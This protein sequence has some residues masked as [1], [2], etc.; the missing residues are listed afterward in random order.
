VSSEWKPVSP[1]KRCKVC[2]S[3]KRCALSSDGAVAKCTYAFDGPNVFKNG[4]DEVGQWAMHRLDGSA[5]V[6]AHTHARRTRD[7]AP[8][9]VL[10]DV[11]TRH[12][13]YTAL[14]AACPL[15]AEHREG[16]LH[17][18]LSAEQI[19][20]RGY[21]TLP[22]GAGPVARV[23][24]QVRGIL[25]LGGDIPDG[26]PGLHRGQLPEGLSGT[27]IPV[28]DARGSVIAMKVRRDGARDPRYLWLSSSR[29]GGASS[30]A[31]AHVPAGVEQYIAAAR[32]A[33]ATGARPEVV[34]RV[35]EGELKADVAFVL[36]GVPTVSI[37]GAGAWR[38][39]IEPV[40]SLAPDVLRLAWDSDA[41]T[42]ENVAAAL[43]TAALR[44]AQE[45]PG[46]AL[47]LETWDAS[48]GKGIDDVLLGG[49]VTTLHR[50]VDMWR[51]IVATLNAAG[52][53]PRAETLARVGVVAVPSVAAQPVAQDSDTSDDTWTETLAR[54][55]RREVTNSYGN[56]AKIIRHAPP[57]A[58]RLRLN[59]MT[60]E[61]E[62]NGAALLESRIGEIREAIEDGPAQWGRF[63]PNKGDV[64]DAVRADAETRSYHPVQEF[65]AKLPPW[66]RTPRI[67]AVAVET[68]GAPNAPLIL[69]M[70]RR[71]FV[72]AVARAMEPGCKVD[73]A[74]VLLG[75]QGHRKSSFFA[76][77]APKWFGDTEIKLGDKDGLQQI[78]HNWIT[79]WAEID[80]ITSVR[81][82][83]EVKTFIARRRDCFR[84]PYGMNTRNYDRS[85]V[86]VGSTNNDG[87]L[88]DPTGGRRFW[89]IPVTRKIDM[90]YVE[91]VRDQLWAE[92]LHVYRAG[93]Q[94]W[95]TDEE[96]GLHATDV[97]QYRVRDPWEEV[98]SRWIDESWPARSRETGRAHFTTWDVMSLALKLDPKDA[99]KETEGRVGSV[100][101]ALGYDRTRPSR[102]E[103]AYL[104]RD[105]NPVQRPRVWVRREGAE[106][107]DGAAAA[108]VDG[109]GDGAEAGDVVEGSA[110]APH[111][112][113]G[114]GHHAGGAS[115]YAP[116]VRA[117]HGP[118]APHAP[119]AQHTQHAPPMGFDD[120]FPFS[121]SD[122][123]IGGLGGLGGAGVLQ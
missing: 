86:I 34:V 29:V 68:M 17:R 109:D 108:D 32:I 100:M 122:G 79:E 104:G 5:P 56:V 26:V 71:W 95:L 23:V 30:H 105:G 120:E 39:A 91:R 38:S 88:S 112:P 55:R 92:A 110:S 43:E 13:V 36:S 12:S 24:A 113:S 73:T 119:H 76:A 52:V 83:G 35:T 78:H 82:A 72:S 28:R 41:R 69:A 116:P 40:R 77:L 20:A 118:H 50:G 33:S 80:R 21:G 115:A 99:R 89:V 44:Y 63:A 93:E 121:S 97:E 85:C 45:L 101:R 84:P 9:P 19:A 102:G 117:Q 106:V 1:S 10:A 11:P 59:T 90:T 14:L 75:E 64:V 87:F 31:P 123:P 49:A 47:E 18:G 54:G 15:G 111:A 16:L 53:D 2:R 46:V 42:N 22:H 62:W 60:Q 37:P 7:A 107:V 51:E 98:V 103:G 94:W 6:D 3:P 61:V 65:F 74:L 48:S 27:L 25:G 81:H 67:E 57:F 114:R 58:G 4:D 66:D 96:E 70:M 8:D